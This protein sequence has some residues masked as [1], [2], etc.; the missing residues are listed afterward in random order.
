[1]AKLDRIN[2]CRRAF[3]I[4]LIAFE[5]YATVFTRRETKRARAYEKSDTLGTKANNACL[6]ISKESRIDRER[7]L[8]QY[9]EFGARMNYHAGKIVRLPVGKCSNATNCGDRRW[10]FLGGMPNG[11]FKRLLDF[12]GSKR[13][14][15]LKM[16]IV[17][18]GEYERITVVPNFP[19]F[20][21]I[22]N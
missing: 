19:S 17:T 18:Q 9:L 3:P 8:E 12:F 2:H 4:L 11:L 5:R 20:A 1:M 10:Q 14:P 6:V 22:R 7:L 15:I 13:L 16:N 21:K